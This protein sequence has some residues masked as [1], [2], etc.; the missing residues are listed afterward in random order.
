MAHT[1]DLIC[2]MCNPFLAAALKLS[3]AAIVDLLE[4]MVNDIRKSKADDARIVAKIV[5]ARK[6]LDDLLG[7][8]DST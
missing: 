1:H 4:T 7:P 6:G 3:P 5:Q 2:H 8:D